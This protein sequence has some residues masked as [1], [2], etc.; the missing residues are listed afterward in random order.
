MEEEEGAPPSPDGLEEAPVPIST[1]AA[2][3]A[4]ESWSFL[5]CFLFRLVGLANSFSLASPLPGR[6]AV[7]SLLES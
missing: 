6:V 7:H 4:L 1:S 5:R 2:G 3:L